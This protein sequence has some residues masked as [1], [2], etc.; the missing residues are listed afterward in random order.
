[1]KKDSNRRSLAF[2]ATAL[3]PPPSGATIM[4]L[5]LNAYNP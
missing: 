1:M 5:T 3:P 2:E 4:H